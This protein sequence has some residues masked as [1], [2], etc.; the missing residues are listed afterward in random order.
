MRDRDDALTLQA[1]GHQARITEVTA[2]P[3]IALHRVAHAA[4][5]VFSAEL[6]SHD[7]GKI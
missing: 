2:Q 4:S 7:F 3:Q 6:W 1:S 5:I